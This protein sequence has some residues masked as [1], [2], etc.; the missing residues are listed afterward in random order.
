MTVPFAETSLPRV[1][2]ATPNNFNL[3]AGAGITL[4]NLFRGW[5]IDR[6]ANVHEDRTPAD[7]SVCRNSFRLTHR[8]VQWAWPFSLIEP[9]A[10]GAQNDYG[11]SAVTLPHPGA[12]WKRCLVGD[13]IPRH[14]TISSSLASWIETF[15]P[16]MIYTHLGS[17]A[18]IRFARAV[19][20][21]WRL[22]LAVHIMDDWPSVVYTTGLLG[23]LLRRIILRDLRDVLARATSRMAISDAMASEYERRY[24]HRFMPFHNAL[25][26]KEWSLASRQEWALNAGGTTVRYVGSIVPEAQRNALREVCDAIAALRED[27]FDITLS[28]HAPA[29]Q[30]APLRAW[31]YS[32]DVLRLAPPAE[33]ADVPRLLSGADILVLPFNFDASSRQY[34]RLSMPTKVPA[35]MISGTPVLVY[36]PREQATVTYAAL[37]RWGETV[38]ENDMHTLKA[39]LRR[40]ITDGDR[41]ER[42]GRAAISLA[43][44]SHDAAR[45]SR[46][47]QNTLASAMDC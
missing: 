4:S 44:Q 14:I 41:R 28:V 18:Q 25:D 17:L 3:E 34:M 33:A 13:G 24:Q 15:K 2:V 27:G 35:Y 8:E 9:P 40:L 43:R 26:M 37:Q 21:R 7:R 5:P 47:F 16:Q 11:T 23:P 42:L 39:A 45:V 38:T 29:A 19:A 31:G 1:L 20:D 6:L 12:A 36:G 32:E 22:P 30:A 10:T 46:A